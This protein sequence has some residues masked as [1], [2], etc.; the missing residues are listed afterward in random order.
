MSR[1]RTAKDRD[2][3]T[4]Q[5]QLIESVKQALGERRYAHAPPPTRRLRC[6]NCNRTHKWSAS[7]LYARCRHCNAGRYQ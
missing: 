1:K 7:V 5:D 3:P 4:T 6:S 2:R